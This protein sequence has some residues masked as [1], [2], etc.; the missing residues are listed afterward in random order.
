MNA[1]K[2]LNPS[3]EEIK[4][5]RRAL[6]DGELEQVSGGSSRFDLQ[7][8]KDIKIIDVVNPDTGLVKDNEDLELNKLVDRPSMGT[9]YPKLI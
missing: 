8:E 7:L 6:T 9:Y 2:E 3:K 4:A 1:K 5:E